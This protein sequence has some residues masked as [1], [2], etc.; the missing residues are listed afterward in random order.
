MS[1]AAANGIYI[2]Y[3]T[4]GDPESRP[5]LLIGGLSDQLIY[6]EDDLWTDLAARGHFIIRFDN[7]DAGL[8][9][10]CDGSAVKKDPPYTL[11]DM[12][13]DAVGLLDTLGINAAHICGASMGGMIA[14]T[15]AIRHPSRTLSLT[16]VYSTTGNKNLPSGDPQVLEL[17]FKPAPTERLAYIDHMVSI[18]KAMSGSGF[19]FDQEWASMMAARAFDRCFCPE[20]T[21]RQ[22]RA[23]MSQEDRRKALASVS[24][25]TL[26][27]HGNEDPVIPVESGIDT[28]DSIPGAELLLIEGMGH[29]L[30]HGGA[31]PQ[32]VDAIAHRLVKA[33]T[34]KVS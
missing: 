6:W 16:S 31:W 2:E 1:R 21:A 11:T 27:V 13:D 8:S 10:K 22:I 7:R 24:V 34:Q 32:I 25:P 12:A 30:P 29:D 18:F 5:L 23:A 19:A 17:L 4:M 14:Q 26:V 15:M 28:V 20:G 3:E 9:T 33:H